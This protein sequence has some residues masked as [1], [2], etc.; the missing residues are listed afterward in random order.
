MFHIIAPVEEESRVLHGGFRTGHFA[1]YKLG[2]RVVFRV[3]I[4]TF[5]HSRLNPFWF[6]VHGYVT[7]LATPRSV[8]YGR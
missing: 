1:T 2:Q 7:R 6:P 3:A 8:L 5:L 4:P